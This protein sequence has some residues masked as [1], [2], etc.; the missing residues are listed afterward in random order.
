MFE[1]SYP[2]TVSGCFG[3]VHDDYW[4]AEANQPPDCSAPIAA[5]RGG[6][7]KRQGLCGAHYTGG[8]IFLIWIV[9]RETIH[10]HARFAL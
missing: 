5:G 4:G 3:A 9:S 1:K 10:M 8:S 7:R 6:P 2:L